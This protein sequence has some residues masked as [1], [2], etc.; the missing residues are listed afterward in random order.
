MIAWIVAGVVTVLFYGM[1]VSLIKRRNNVK[2]S[3]SSI[4]VHLKL[5]YDLI[6]N[7]L[8]AA[9][10]YMEH[11]KDV[12]MQ[13]TELREKALNAGNYAD[14]FEADR[15]LTGAMR[16]FNIKAENYPDLKSDN[17][18]L[19]AQKAMADVEEHISAARRFYNSAVKD[20]KNG[21]EIF[22]SS[23]VAKIIGLKDEYP[24]F[25]AEEIAKEAIDVNNFFN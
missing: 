7:M 5:R 8:K 6:P 4:D 9:A 24:F 1:Y 3:A 18:M 16:A 14:K 20:Y 12:F 2:E 19:A 23:M 11:E 22:P 15:A 17:T 10:K 25:E 13:V 21:I